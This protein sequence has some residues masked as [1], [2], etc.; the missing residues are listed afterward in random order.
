MR[1]LTRYILREVLSYAVLGGVMFTFIL[2]TTR[3]GS[4]LEIFV[5]GSA[6]LTDVVRL[7]AYFLPEALVVTIPMAVLVGILLGL[8]RLA[9]D[10]EITAMRAAGMGAFDFVR[11]ISLVS[12]GAL[13]LGL[14]NSLYLLPHS[15]A[16]LLQLEDRLKYAQASFA[17]EPRVFDEDFK[18]TVLY[19]QEVRPGTGAALWR[20]VFIADLTE[21]AS[22]RITT[23]V[24]AVVTQEASTEGPSGLHLL[25]K[26][27]GEH[28]ISDTDPNQYNI[29][30]FATADLPMQ[31]S[32]QDDTHISRSNTH[33]EAL[34]LPE[35]R[36]RASLSDGF[37]GAKLSRPYRIELNKRF[38]YPFACLVLMLVGVP[39]GLSSKRGGKST[40]FV[41][42]ILLVFGYYLL[43]SIGVAL[44]SQG[45]LSPLL[46]V[47]GANILF[48]L[49]GL[50]LLQQMSAGGLALALVSG[51]GLK[52]SA[53]I[54]KLRPGH[55]SEK[56]EAEQTQPDLGRQLA[57][58]VSSSLHIRFPLILDEYIMRAFSSNFA[59]VLATFW[60]LFTIF[61][62]FE[63]IGDIIRNRTPLVTV[64]D[65]LLNLTPF[66][67]YNITPMC[68][69]VAVLITFGAL[70]R[71]SEI[72][73]MKAA[74]ISLYRI[75]IPVLVLTAIIAVSLFAFDE[76]YL[77]AANRRQEALRSVIKGKP[78][79]TFLRPDRSW[80][81][82]Q[83]TPPPEFSNTPPAAHATEP[84]RIFYY[85]FF[86]PDRNVFANLTVFE[87]DP[88][89]FTL[90][91][92]IFAASARWDGRVD[93][94]LFENGWV[95]TFSGESVASYDPFLL[96]TFPTIREQPQY[97]KKED[98]QSQEMNFG[99]LSSY[100]NDLRQSG[101]DTKK[102]SVQLDLKL[103]YPAITLVMAMLALPFAFSTGKRGG[104]AGFAVAIL[105]A[106]IYSGASKLF[107]AMGNV[108]TLPPLLAAWSPDLLFALA[109]SYLL[110]RTPT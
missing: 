86:D 75:V 64:G 69:L 41:L 110:L 91:R 23:A 98:R 42:T 31:S 12:L 90:Q 60:I 88:V 45:K 52:L 18:N 70:S 107:E 81:S 99:E 55:T 20:H 19:V 6:S 89:T 14:A 84:V 28:Q 65:Y 57:Q 25:L 104:V 40:G 43:S 109:G 74:G 13:L 83:T 10:S 72:T 8:S 71:S 108:N 46:G 87:F 37:N 102:L 96:T 34:S 76:F 24:Q 9:A 26:D 73:A 77:P 11:I 29:E 53:A 63:L 1:I 50:I 3:L 7:I 4:I 78:A 59:L 95:R 5:R 39:L 35:L 36:A 85:Q 61:T 15:A 47:W 56:R 16:A 103:A 22:P 54:A 80:I 17:V 79:Q 49:A 66:I 27:G 32:A 33:V 67:L 48:A 82:G 94:W 38:S 93:R 58:H 92:R 2:F 21:P 106:L 105:I 51:I 44:A 101:F 30:T 62:F 100:I 68:V 97:F